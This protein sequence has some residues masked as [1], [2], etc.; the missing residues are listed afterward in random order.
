[1]KI[2]CKKDYIFIIA[3]NIKWIRNKNNLTL[4]EMAKIL[5]TS[6]Y[7]LKNLESGILPKRLGADILFRI[8]S[9]FNIPVQDIVDRIL[10]D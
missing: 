3:E 8:Q 1:M 6:T 5:E 4:D 7:S 10:K 9:Y 2:N